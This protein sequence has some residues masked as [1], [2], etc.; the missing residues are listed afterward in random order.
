MPEF[1]PRFMRPTEAA[2]Y[3]GM[4][5]T[6]FDTEIRPHIPAIPIGKQGIGFD[7]IDL[8]AALDNYKTRNL[9]PGVTTDNEEETPWRNEAT[10]GC[11]GT[12]KPA[13]AAS[14]SASA[15][16]AFDTALKRARDKKPKPNTSPPSTA[17]KPNG[18]GPANPGS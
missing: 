13:K 5:R 14:T 12:R 1:P 8:D 17:P 11:T 4:G 18:R 9:S 10:Q 2:Y 7:R 15:E 6:L 3:C 16:S